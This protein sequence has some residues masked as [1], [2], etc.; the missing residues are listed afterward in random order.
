MFAILSASFGPYI[1]GLEPEPIIFN[2]VHFEKNEFFYQFLRI[3]CDL[4]KYTNISRLDHQWN[5]VIIFALSLT[6]FM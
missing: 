1:V 3:V 5:C 4:Q 6:F 2:L